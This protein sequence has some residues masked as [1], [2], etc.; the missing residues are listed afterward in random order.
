MNE[1]KQI[2]WPPWGRGGIACK[3]MLFCNKYDAGCWVF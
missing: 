2:L 3:R 1:M